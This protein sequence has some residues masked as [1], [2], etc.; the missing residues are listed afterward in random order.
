MSQV[1]THTCVV[2]AVAVVVVDE[3]ASHHVDADVVVE[4]CDEDDGKLQRLPIVHVST[5]SRCDD[6]VIVTVVII[7]IILFKF[8]YYYSNYFF[9][10][11]VIESDG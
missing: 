1:C 3:N 10:F 8:S 6:I 9:Y 2:A 4:D 11:S 7:M 5:I